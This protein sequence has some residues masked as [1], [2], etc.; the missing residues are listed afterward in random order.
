MVYYAT[1]E[2]QITLIETHIIICIECT[3]RSCRKGH[4]PRQKEQAQRHRHAVI[5][6][7]RNCAIPSPPQQL[8]YCFLHFVKQTSTS[9]AKLAGINL[10]NCSMFWPSMFFGNLRVAFTTPAFSAKK[11]CATWFVPGSSELSEATKTALSQL[12][13]NW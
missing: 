8:T 7:S 5:S 9:C 13:L 6:Q 11:P 1:S 4:S 3:T 10:R 2:W 12:S